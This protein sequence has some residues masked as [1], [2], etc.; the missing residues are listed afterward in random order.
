MSRLHEA[1]IN[2]DIEGVKSYLELGD[3]INDF[4]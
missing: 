1:A 2:D 4:I 3:K